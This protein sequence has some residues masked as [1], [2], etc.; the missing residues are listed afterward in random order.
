MLKQERIYLHTTAT[1]I[2]RDLSAP[3]KN[4][5]PRESSRQTKA[6][7]LVVDP[8]R[9]ER[10][11][12]STTADSGSTLHPIINH[13]EATTTSCLCLRHGMSQ[14]RNLSIAPSRPNPLPLRTAMHQNRIVVLSVSARSS[15]CRRPGRSCD[16]GGRCGSPRRHGANDPTTRTRSCR[17]RR[18][19]Q[20]EEQASATTAQGK[21]YD[22]GSCGTGTTT[23]HPRRRATPKTRATPA[24]RR[25]QKDRPEG[26]NCPGRSD[27]CG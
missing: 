14:S 4:N 3:P 1:Q 15:R 9:P 17:F 21:D 10:R 16:G 13:G 5:A 27:Q 2:F 26:T 8:H 19:G 11:N 6:K 7:I 12:K 23:R 18:H 24:A 20:E 22:Y 25:Q